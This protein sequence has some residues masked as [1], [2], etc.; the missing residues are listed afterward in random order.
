MAT[1]ADSD[2]V[3]TWQFSH[4]RH[5]YAWDRLIDFHVFY[6]RGPSSAVI[7]SDTIVTSYVIAL[8]NGNKFHVKSCYAVARDCQD[9]FYW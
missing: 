4:Q 5:R 7:R 2:N 3:S 9:Y 6:M 1:A 8:G